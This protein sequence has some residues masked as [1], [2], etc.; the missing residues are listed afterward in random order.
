M[1]EMTCKMFLKVLCYLYAIPWVH[2]SKTK[3]VSTQNIYMQ[4]I[5]TYQELRSPPKKVH[6]NYTRFKAGKK[7]KIKDFTTGTIKYKFLTFNTGVS[8]LC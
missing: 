4:T 5:Q 3:H 8:H 1:R 7:N 6:S 2:I